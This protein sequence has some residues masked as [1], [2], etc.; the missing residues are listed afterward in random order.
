MMLKAP[1]TIATDILIFFSIFQRNVSLDILCESSKADNSHEISKPYS[2]RK[3]YKKKRMSSA[4]N[5]TWRFK[6]KSFWQ[7]KH[8]F[9]GAKIG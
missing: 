8:A 6:V 4:I 3:I 5:F 2:L 7:K 9:S 1:F